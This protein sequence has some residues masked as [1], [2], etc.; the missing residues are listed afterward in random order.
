MFYALLSFPNVV[1][2]FSA[3]LTFQTYIG[4]RD[5]LIERFAHVINR[6]RRYRNRRE[7]LH[8]NSRLCVR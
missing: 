6:K 4:N 1:A 7:R 3:R 8:L 2:G 5:S